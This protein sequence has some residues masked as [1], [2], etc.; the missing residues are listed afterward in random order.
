[1]E[2]FA[3]IHERNFDCSRTP[4]WKRAKA[5]SPPPTSTQGGETRFVLSLPDMNLFTN[6][7]GMDEH[8][9]IN[10]LYYT[11]AL[12]SDKPNTNLLETTSRGVRK[13]EVSLSEDFPQ[14]TKISLT[15]C[16][17]YRK[18]CHPTWEIVLPI[19]WKCPPYR[20]Q[21]QFYQKNPCRQGIGRL[22]HLIII[23]RWPPR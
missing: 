17:Q 13:A 8:Q 18:H 1:M 22:P 4:R 7:S 5:H 6:K 10:L 3:I 19:P 21:H 15:R 2:P 9:T 11:Y 16:L 23:T 14:L 20:Q 12:V